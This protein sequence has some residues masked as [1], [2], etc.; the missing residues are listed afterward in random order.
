MIVAKEENF[1]LNGSVTV[2]PGLNIQINDNEMDIK[3]S[4]LEEN[5]EKD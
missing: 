3:D 4:A 1:T 2:L 5:Y